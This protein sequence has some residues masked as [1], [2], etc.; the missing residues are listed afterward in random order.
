M[1]M[2]KHQFLALVIGLCFSSLGD[3]QKINRQFEH[4]R[5]VITSSEVSGLRQQL[6]QS[7][8]QSMF[9]NIHETV[10]SLTKEAKTDSNVYTISFLMVNQAILHLLSEKPEWAKKAYNNYRILYHDSSILNNSV[11]FGLTRAT[12]LYNMALTYDFCFNAWNLPERKTASQ[13]LFELMYSVNASMGYSANYALASNWMG[14]RYGSVILAAAVYDD[15]QTEAD[16]H[17]QPRSLPFLWDASRR[18]REHFDASL[19]SNGWHMESK[20]YHSYDWQFSIPAVIALQNRYQLSEYEL[21]H[22]APEALHSLH[23]IATSTVNIKYP[24]GKGIQPDFSDNAPSTGLRLFNL[25][26]AA[27]PDKQLPYIKWMHQYLYDSTPY[28]DKRG[29]LLYALI[30][31]PENML[32]QNPE[33]AGWLN[34]VDEE[35]GVVLFRNQF[36]NEADIVAAFKTTNIR[37]QGHTGADNLGFRIIGLGSIW[38][39]GGGRT[40]WVKGQTTLFPH[41]Q[42]KKIRNQRP[43]K[44]GNLLNYTTN[45][46]GSGYAVGSGSCM[47]V[48]NHKRYFWADYNQTSG[49]EA[50]FAVLDSSDNGK[51]WRLNTPEFNTINLHN[52]GFTLTAPN[53]N[54]LKATVVFPENP[55]IDTGRVRYG[56]ETIRHN[57]GICYHDSCYEYS[58]TIDIKCKGNIMVVM[59]LQQEGEEHPEV[60]IGRDKQRIHIGKTILNINKK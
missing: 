45:K 41:K 57:P 12:V 1:G 6:H 53:N 13:H 22:Y 29:S 17:K 25:G 2:M 48:R 47:G 44:T 43:N 52:D 50:V 5:G 51:Y 38:A 9:R 55:S 23:G 40:N 39:V 30:A 8:Y 24:G 4:P 15:Y 26:L 60:K 34:Y 27:Y 59:T 21:H 19:T 37:P 58:K 54:S 33:K 56:G 3:A 32:A 7:P 11:S 10:E 49:A 18:L 28:H 35:M 46:D 31:Y 16:A 20:G 36:K 42:F 14:V